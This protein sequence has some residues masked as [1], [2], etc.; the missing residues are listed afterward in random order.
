MRADPCLCFSTFLSSSGLKQLLSMFFDFF[1]YAYEEGGDDLFVGGTSSTFLQ[2]SLPAPTLMTNK[3]A[4]K[5]CLQMQR[6][7]G[8]VVVAFCLT[9]LSCLI[10]E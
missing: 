8:R 3:E 5:T 10:L 1:V 6:D 2:H 7:D 4:A 9:E